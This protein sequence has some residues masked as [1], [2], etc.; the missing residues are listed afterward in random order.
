M[1]MW[2]HIHAEV[3]LD[4]ISKGR[5]FAEEYGTMVRHTKQ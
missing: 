1:R 5:P 2:L 4:H 3:K